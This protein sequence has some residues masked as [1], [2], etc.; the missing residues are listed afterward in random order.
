MAYFPFWHTLEYSPQAYSCGSLNAGFLNCLHRRV[1]VHVYV[2]ERGVPFSS[3]RVCTAPTVGF[4]CLSDFSVEKEENVT[5][6]PQ[7]HQNLGVGAP[8]KGGEDR[9]MSTG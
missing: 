3:T 7:K 8:R 1:H 4:A 5:L 6:N 9:P 2:A